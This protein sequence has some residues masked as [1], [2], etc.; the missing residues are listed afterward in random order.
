MEG[1][2]LSTQ[3]IFSFHAT[4]MSREAGVSGYFCAHGVR[5]KFLERLAQFG[6]TLPSH[7]FDPER[8]Y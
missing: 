8:R 2:T 6:I 7:F 4:G 1:D 3:E 5:P